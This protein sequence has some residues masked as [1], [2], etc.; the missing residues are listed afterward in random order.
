MG[1]KGATSRSSGPRRKGE[2]SGAHDVS[3]VQ[4]TVCCEVTLTE[5]AD[6]LV[7]VVIAQVK[8]AR[9]SWSKKDRGQEARTPPSR[10][11]WQLARGKARIQSHADHTWIRGRWFQFRTKTL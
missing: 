8:K 1:I 7:T 2:L 4:R 11:E 9:L 6:V 10:N 3:L 5:P